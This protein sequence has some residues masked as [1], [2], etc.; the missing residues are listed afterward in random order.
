MV[1]LLKRNRS[2]KPE[3]GGEA[4]S[5][6]QRL[7]GMNEVSPNKPEHL[8]IETTTH[9]AE[10]MRK[11]REEL[12]RLTIERDI[13]VAGMKH[14]YEAET[15]GKIDA[16]TKDEMIGKYKND[17]GRLDEELAARKRITEA[18][19]LKTEREQLIIRL[20]EIDQQ[21][22][23]YNSID[24]HVATQNLDT[25]LSPL[26]EADSLTVVESHNRFHKE[27]ERQI[28]VRQRAEERVEA[29]RAEVLQ[30]M[31]RLERIEAEG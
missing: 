12:K 31:E 13:I 2:K 11:A 1:L 9:T 16:A 21:L 5:T 4:L 23:P 18:Q 8:I 30:A 3:K 6:E 10:E 20:K 7:S 24:P 25:P 29:I 17:L 15:K 22:E 27:R 19:D 14:I 26:T 28:D